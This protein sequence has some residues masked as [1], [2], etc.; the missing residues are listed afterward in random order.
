MVAI[1]YMEHLL[2]LRAILINN[3]LLFHDNISSIFI[4]TCLTISICVEELIIININLSSRFICSSWNLYLVVQYWVQLCAVL[5][6]TAVAT[7]SNYFDSF[8]DLAVAANFVKLLGCRVPLSNYASINDV[9]FV[10]RFFFCR[11]WIAKTAAKTFL[12][13]IVI[14][15]KMTKY[16]L[17]ACH[18]FTNSMLIA[19]QCCHP[20]MK[21]RHM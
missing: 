15:H 19:R 6:W 13:C 18:L 12:R 17:I 10:V 1:N 9:S 20:F 11:M 16:H 5:H 21:W 7:F 14:S 4:Y 3:W 8:A 2:L